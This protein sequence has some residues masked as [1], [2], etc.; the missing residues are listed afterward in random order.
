MGS[1][2]VCF[3]DGLLL[4]FTSER[5]IEGQSF[6]S[7]GYDRSVHESVVLIQEIWAGI[8]LCSTQTA[9]CE[10]VL[11]VD[12]YNQGALNCTDDWLARSSRYLQMCFLIHCI[13]PDS[14][15]SFPE[16]QRCSAAT[17]WDHEA[18]V[19]SQDSWYST[20]VTQWIS[21]ITVY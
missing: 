13:F 3:A 12:L 16:I 17:S 1:N 5:H 18:T 9:Y 21:V 4:S 10:A 20:V 19:V 14:L 15:A 7:C 6:R 11:S 2:S 8:V